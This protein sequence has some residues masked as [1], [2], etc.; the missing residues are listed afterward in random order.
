MV[1]PHRAGQRHRPARRRNRS[2]PVGA[3]PARIPAVL[4]DVAAATGRPGRA[5]VTT[6]PRSTC[7]GSAPATS[8]RAGTTC[9]PWPTTS[10][11]WSPPSVNATRCWS[12]TTSAG[13]WPGRW[14]PATRTS[15]AASS[16]SPRRIRC[17]C[18]RA[19]VRDPGGQ[20]RALLPALTTFQIPRRPERLL[21]RD[22]A[23]VHGLFDACSGP[24]WRGA[25]GLRRRRRA[26]RRVDAREQGRLLR[27]GVFPLG[28]PL[29]A[30]PGRPSRRATAARGRR[31]CP[32]CN[33]TARSTTGCWPAPRRG[34]GATCTPR[35][36]WRLL[37]GRRTLPAGRGSR[38][39]HRRA[40]RVDRPRDLNFW[41]AGQPERVD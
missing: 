24:A 21:K 26:L 5:P 6:R 29:R 28:V 27:D 1:A 4:V 15:C 16:R 3:V 37:G 30:A 35:Y 39:G 17:G 13:W 40:H 10:P 11:A 2:G 22:T 32:C 19:C 23:Y 34:P 33:C 36:D 12:A 31:P 7:A 41:S 20:G 9:P 14:R 25:T 38:R 18:A 8:P